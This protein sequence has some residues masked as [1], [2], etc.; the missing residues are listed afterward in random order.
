MSVNSIKG[1]RSSATH[2][3]HGTHGAHGPQAQGKS[4]P[5]K[6]KEKAQKLMQD[7]SKKL[8]AGDKKGAEKD[9]E[10]LSKALH[11]DPKNLRKALGLDDDDNQSPVGKGGRGG[12]A[13]GAGGGGGG[14]ADRKST[15][16]NS[17]HSGESRMPS[18]A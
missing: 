8:Q 7:I 16:L 10:K 11:T 5:V 2:G 17:S 12:H 3:T 14:G 6:G 9:I 18:S 1:S 15:R 4:E 13:K